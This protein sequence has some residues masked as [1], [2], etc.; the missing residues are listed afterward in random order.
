MTPAY[1]ES[2]FCLMEL[3]AAWAKSTKSLPIVVP[4]IDFELVTKTLGLKQAWKITDKSG[5]VDLKE[6]VRKAVPNLEKRSEHTWDEK[7]IKWGIDLKKTLSQL[8][9]A[10]KIGAEE[11]QKAVIALKEREGEVDHLETALSEAQE[12]IG[13]L[14]KLKDM[15]GVRALKKRTRHIEA[16]QEEFDSLISAVESSKPRAANVVIRHIISDHYNRAGRI[17]WFNYRSEF[18]DA[19]KY[20]LLSADGDDRV[21]WGRGKLREFGKAL[22]NVDTFLSSEEGELFR[23]SQNSDLPMEPDDL[24]F[25]ER[26]LQLW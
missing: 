13:E 20:G 8:Q 23:E 1:M 17:D 22:D 21:E 24:E 18:D 15:D 6:T 2:R 3:G 16:L 25:W 4:P 14:E 10:T 12:K 19:V 26:H 9:K 7:R 5:L 11:H